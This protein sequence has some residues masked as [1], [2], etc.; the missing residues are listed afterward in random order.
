MGDSELCRLGIKVEAK[1]DSF[2][3]SVGKLLLGPLM[4]KGDLM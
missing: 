4:R 2:I 3:I 1:G